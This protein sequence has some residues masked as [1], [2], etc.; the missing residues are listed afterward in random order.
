VKAGIKAKKLD[1]IPMTIFAKGAH[2]A[3]QDLA[4]SGY[5]VVGIDWTIDPEEARQK[6]GSDV[7][8]Q[9]NL[10]PCA[11]YAPEAD[12]K[13]HTRELLKKFGKHRYIANLGHGIYP[14]MNPDHVATL[15]ETVHEV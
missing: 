13:K 12:L 1:D 15:I 14:D 9:G 11:L 10:D 4:Q 6:V 8:L 3:L 5:D 7:T 2:Y